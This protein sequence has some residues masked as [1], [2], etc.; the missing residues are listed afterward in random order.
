MSML[1]RAA[2]PETFLVP[3]QRILEEP[4]T[5]LH[6]K[7][8]HQAATTP[9]R[10]VIQTP[11]GCFTAIIPAVMR[12]NLRVGMDVLIRGTLR[13]RRTKHSVFHEILTVELTI[14]DPTDGN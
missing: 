14:T 5:L 12:E 8:I 9:Q 11:T 4:T 7:L 6:G 2:L 1:P 3:T 13:K 10:F